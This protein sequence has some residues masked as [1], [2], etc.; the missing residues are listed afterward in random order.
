[1]ADAVASLVLAAFL[2]MGAMGCYALH[3]ILKEIRHLRVEVWRVQQA[4]REQTGVLAD[5]L[6]GEDP[7]PDDD[8]EPHQESERVVQ[9]NPNRAA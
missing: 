2:C 7:D 9:F 8:G 3:E 4:V 5:W 1:M 6:D